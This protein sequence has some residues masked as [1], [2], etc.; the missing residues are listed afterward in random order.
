[1]RRCRP[2]NCSAMR[3]AGRSSRSEAETGTDTKPVIAAAIPAMDFRKACQVVEQRLLPDGVA[4]PCP[5]LRAAFGEA[6]EDPALRRGPDLGRPSLAGHIY[7]GIHAEVAAAVRG[8]ATRFLTHE[9][10]CTVN[11]AIASR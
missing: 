7:P 8:L 10:R 3:C 1:M 6:A 9:A 4:V 5:F 2:V 11:D